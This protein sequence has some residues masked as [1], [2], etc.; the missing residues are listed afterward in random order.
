MTTR[1]RNNGF[2]LI[3]LMVTVA[4]LAILAAI[5]YPSYRDQILKS[6][7]G[8]AQTALLEIAQR[9]ER[10]YAQN[11]T[12]T[13]DMTDLGY[14][15]AGWND[16]GD[17][18]EVRILAAADACPVATCYG[19]AAQARAGTDQANDTIQGYRLSSRGEKEKKIGGTWS[20]GWSH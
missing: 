11:A 17:Y 13:V 15:A 10:F 5:A 19:V 9:Q 1:C 4:I 2:S 14:G 3:E 18:Y 12:Y 7:R 8:D 20:E 16:T 6:R